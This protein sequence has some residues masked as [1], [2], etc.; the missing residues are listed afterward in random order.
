M[1]RRTVLNNGVTVLTEAVPGVRSTA[2][3]LLVD[4]GP[5]DDPAGK[6]GL[7]HFTEHALFQGT[8]LRDAA[9]IA[10]L[11]DTAGGQIGA[12]TA[13]DYTCY[14]A[15]VLDDYTTYAMDLLGDLFS[16]STFPEAQLER[17]KESIQREIELGHDS[18]AEHAH[19]LLKSSVW[20]N[21]P[22]GWPIEGDAASVKSFTRDDVTAFVDRNYRPGRIIAIA[23]GNVA[24]DDFVAQT[25]DALWQLTGDAVARSPRPVT[26]TPAVR[27]AAADV[28]Q[29]YLAVGVPFAPFT[30][31]E[32]Y[33]EHLLTCVLGGGMSSR[34]FTRLR[35]QNGLVYHIQSTIHAYRDGG[36]LVI[37][38]GCRPE[39]VRYVLA[40]IMIELHG[41]ASGDVPVDEEEL[42][43]ARMQVRGQHLLSSESMHTRMSRLATQQFYF[44]RRIEEQEIVRQ[45]DGVTCDTLQRIAAERIGRQWDQ[46]AV[47][48]V[49]PEA[50]AECSAE[51]L[52]EVLADFAPLATA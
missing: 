7:A 40:Q 14:Y 10:R 49:G 44:G 29:V 24:H 22:L 16:N 27:V 8:S 51:S 5:Y 50:R 46:I 31:D 42:W 11:I 30:S 32:R 20:P 28:S 26:F 13:R 52:Q 48:A 9:A 43:T 6:R 34:L 35:E 3:G 41:L 15:H 33:A 21:H 47:A 36:L 37:E 25:E 38:S 39:H 23:A 1:Y 18:P 12:F 4:A 2:I 45:L 19:S 17:E